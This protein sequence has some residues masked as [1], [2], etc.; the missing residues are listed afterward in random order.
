MSSGIFITFEGTDGSGK[1]TQIR[2]LKDALVAGGFDP[3]VTREP[4]G[5]GIGEL[6][7]AIILD[8][9]HREMSAVTEM[10]LYAASRAQHVDEVIRPNLEAGRI[11]ISDRFVDSSIA[12]QGGARG[13]GRIVAEVNGYAVREC[14]PDMTFLLCAAADS[15]FPRIKT[16]SEDRIEA[17]G[18]AMQRRVAEAYGRLA[19]EY[20]SRITVIDASEP[21]GAIH[22]RIAKRVL[23][24]LESS[25]SPVER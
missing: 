12:Y 16:G 20:P 4:G 5:T 6:I 24:L 25:G 11:V 19:E 7:R 23:S 8:P 2:L 9:S 3:V 21:I 22:A 17:E 14:M 13:L 18:L 15:V 1:S 10:M